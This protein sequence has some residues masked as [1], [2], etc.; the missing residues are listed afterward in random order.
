MNCRCLCHRRQA[1]ARSTFIWRRARVAAGRLQAAS[2]SLTLCFSEDHVALFSSGSIIKR[3]SHRPHPI[4]AVSVPIPFSPSLYPFLVTVTSCDHQCGFPSN[5][6]TRSDPM[7]SCC[8]SFAD[9]FVL[10]HRTLNIAGINLELSSCQLPWPMNRPA[11]IRFLATSDVLSDKYSIL[12]LSSVPYSSYSFRFSYFIL[13]S[14][15][16]CPHL[17]ISSHTSS[18]QLACLKEISCLPVVS[19]RSIPGR[20][21]SVVPSQSPAPAFTG[22]PWTFSQFQLF[23]VLTFSPSL[24]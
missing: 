16:K 13:T 21:S 8:F 1:A 6:C 22:L 4:Q 20:R 15:L 17:G 18:P 12:C 19:V 23:M 3:M 7:L 9:L 5:R 14:P 2:P 11:S 10:F 24:F